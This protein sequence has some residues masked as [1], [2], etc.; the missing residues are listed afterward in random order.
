[1]QRLYLQILAIGRAVVKRPTGSRNSWGRYIEVAPGDWNGVT[2]DA[3]GNSW[4]SNIFLDVNSTTTQIGFAKE[5]TDRMISPNCT[6][7][8]GIKARSYLGG[9]KS[10]WSVPTLAEMQLI[11]TLASI[12]PRIINEGPSGNVGY[13]VSNGG[14]GDGRWVASVQVVGGGTGGVNKAGTSP[15]LRPIRYF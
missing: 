15:Y 9:G 3:T 5:N 1:V 14:T 2:G 12:V 7:G 13:W 8:I 6:S 11:S 4:C 10:D